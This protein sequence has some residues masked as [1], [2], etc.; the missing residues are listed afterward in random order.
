MSVYDPLHHLG[1]PVVVQSTALAVLLLCM[2]GVMVRRQ[3]AASGGGVLPDEGVTVR[4]VFELI[5]E[6]LGQIA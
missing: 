4:N 5:I 1:V 3:I 2:C 6:N